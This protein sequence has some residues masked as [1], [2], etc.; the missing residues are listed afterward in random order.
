MK[1][2]IKKETIFCR[3]RTSAKSKEKDLERR[4]EELQGEIGNK[5]G[6]TENLEL[7]ADTKQTVEFNRI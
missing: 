2:K 3:N 4:L 1:N 7:L 5:R 6:V